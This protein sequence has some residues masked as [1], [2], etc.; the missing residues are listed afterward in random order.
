M[1]PPVDTEFY[2]PDDRPAGAYALIVSALVPYKRID[3]AVDASRL[4]GI[5]LK[6]AGDGPDRA[7]LQAHA[8]G[9][10]VE[11]LG[12]QTNESVRDL[13]RGAGMVL[14]PG[15]E[16]FGIAPVEAQACGR[17]VV[18]YGRGGARETVLDR[19]TGVLVDEMS[20]AALAEGMA[21]VRELHVDPGVARA[22]A[23]RFSRQRFQA[24]M[25]RLVEETRSAPE[26][27]RW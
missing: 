23:V 10:D 5:P 16:D 8:A 22:H 25:V 24:E 15:E 7:R 2:A 13:Y 17:P 11:F 4:A 14:L 19:V 21:E 12:F 3:V 9:A 20:P 18:A 1:Y 6:I 27:T 26:G